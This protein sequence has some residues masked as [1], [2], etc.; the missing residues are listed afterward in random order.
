MIRRVPKLE[1]KMYLDIGCGDK[2]SPGYIGMDI[3]DCGQH[4]LWDCRQGIPFPDSSIDNIRSS[5]FLEHLSDEESIDFLQ[6]IMRVL[7]HG[8]HFYCRVPHQNTPL[9]YYYGHK[10]FWNQHRVE[11][12]LRLTEKIQPFIIEQNYQEGAELIFTFKKL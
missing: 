4:I 8:G 2:P 6:E 7:K 10:T 3:R 1:K 11:S 12:T 9:A 5:H